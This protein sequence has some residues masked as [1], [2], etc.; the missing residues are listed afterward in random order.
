M[1]LKPGMG[2]RSVASGRRQVALFNSV[3]KV[4]LTKQV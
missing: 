3:V 1:M 2:V 4:G